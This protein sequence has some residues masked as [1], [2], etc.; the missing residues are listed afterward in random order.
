MTH[1]ASAQTATDTAAQA[2]GTTAQAND[3][4]TH[5]YDNAHA[6]ADAQ[7]KL[8][9]WDYLKAEQSRVA[10]NALP[11]T[12]GEWGS[13]PWTYDPSTKTLVIAPDADAVVDWNTA[14]FLTGDDSEQATKQNMETVQFA[15]RVA[16][17]DPNALDQ[18]FFSAEHLK[19]VEHIDR[20]SF[21]QLAD[22]RSWV[23]FRNMFGR[24]AV[25]SVDFAQMQLHDHVIDA[26]A[27]FAESAVTDIQ[28]M[29]IPFA[30]IGCALGM[31]HSSQLHNVVIEDELNAAPATM[32]T[33]VTEMFKNCEDLQTVVWKL[34]APNITT[35]NR[36][37]TLS[38]VKSIDLDGMQSSSISEADEAFSDCHKLETL[39]M[40]NM[41]FVVGYHDQLFAGVSRTLHTI[42]LTKASVNHLYN[43]HITSIYNETNTL[44]LLND[45]AVVWSVGDEPKTWHQWADNTTIDPAI[46]VTFNQSINKKANTTSDDETSATNTTDESPANDNGSLDP[47]EGNWGG[48]PWYIDAEGQELIIA[49][50]QD[51]EVAMGTPVFTKHIPRMDSIRAKVRF[52]RFAHAVTIHNEHQLEDMFLGFESLTAVRNIG[53]L[54]FDKL[55]DAHSV[56]H[57]SQ[58]FAGT[59]LQFVDFSECDF[60]EHSIN[61]F[62]LF[63]GAAT[64]NSK[65]FNIPFN[66]IE[67]SSQMFAHTKNLKKAFINCSDA[68]K[69]ANQWVYAADMFKGSGITQVHWNIYAPR[70]RDTARMFLSCKKLTD[71]NANPLSSKSLYDT[72]SMFSRCTSLQ[73]LAL[74]GTPFLNPYT[75][76][77]FKQVPV[78]TITLS[79]ATLLHQLT[80]A[81]LGDSDTL[82]YLKV[83][84]VQW[85][86]NGKQQSWQQWA[87]DASLTDY[88]LEIEFAQVA[89]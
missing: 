57:L 82:P 68:D 78:S 75:D 66:R 4:G 48:T 30:H 74:D 42:T 33:D 88:G 54:K 53:N 86:A 56:I 12:S 7:E 15:H 47:M 8:S 76:S 32:W 2:F 58:M 70:L 77:V 1:S 85:E 63:Y 59:N 18:L 36:M 9:E 11:K 81:Q 10:N 35:M 79:R 25:T 13:V 60:G 51:A 62:G 31:F 71:L 61:A 5:V 49:P 16:I 65:N 67:D 64:T 37:F 29:H 34:Y 20:I 14:E 45:T 22:A 41:H 69:T 50:K 44:P 26:T 3:D 6:D 83:E 39:S 17:Q 73:F 38:S 89:A 80:R 46:S 40:R 84:H 21:D 72:T 27:M 23:S 52:V 28:R 87:E 24:T 43:L 19:T 55:P